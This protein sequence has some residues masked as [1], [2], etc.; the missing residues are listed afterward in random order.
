MAPP[1]AIRKD[2]E[3]AGNNKDASEYLF[4]VTEHGKLKYIK[5]LFYYI[6]HTL[7]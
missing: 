7:V 3:S 5:F 4:S 1:V 6:Y 2:Y